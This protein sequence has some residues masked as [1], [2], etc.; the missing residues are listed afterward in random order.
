MMTGAEVWKGNYENKRTNARYQRYSKL[1]ISKLSS[2]LFQYSIEW[3]KRVWNNVLY[4]KIIWKL[5]SSTENKH[6]NR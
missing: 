5:L 6:E 1:I 3:S 2:F 4:Q